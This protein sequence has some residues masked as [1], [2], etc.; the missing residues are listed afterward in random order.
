MAS[1]RRHRAIAWKKRSLW[2]EWV[3]RGRLRIEPSVP[4]IER[5]SHQ[6]WQRPLAYGLAPENRHMDRF[7]SSGRRAR[8]N[9]WTPRS[10]GWF[11]AAATDHLSEDPVKTLA[12]H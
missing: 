7:A 9:H 6:G 10:A 2:M 5:K 12:T 8:S 3:P 1:S 11:A 4:G